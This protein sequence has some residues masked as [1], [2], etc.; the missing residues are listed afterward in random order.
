MRSGRTY[1]VRAEAIERYG[2]ETSKPPAKAG[3]GS[4]QDEATARRR[5]RYGLRE[6]GA[7]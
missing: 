4:A 5:A 2:I 6:K 3:A 1:F 7:A